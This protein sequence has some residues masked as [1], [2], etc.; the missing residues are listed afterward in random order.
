MASVGRPTGNKNK[1]RKESE[2]MEK[3]GT[4]GAEMIVRP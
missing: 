1:V 3:Y 4:V 2:S